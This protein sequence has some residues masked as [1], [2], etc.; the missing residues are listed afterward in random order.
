MAVNLVN[1]SID[2]PALTCHDS[3][4]REGSPAGNEFSHVI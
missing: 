4:Q 1:Q 3:L 2:S